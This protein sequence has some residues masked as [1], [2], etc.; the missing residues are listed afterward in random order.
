MDN[1]LAMRMAEAY[2]SEAHRHGY[3]EYL[4]VDGKVDGIRMTERGS[5]MLT[6]LGLLASPG[7]LLGLL[8][9]ADGVKVIE[10]SGGVAQW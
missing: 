9:A 7:E 6:T 1:D 3:V 10:E 8:S 4:V 5:F 2:Q